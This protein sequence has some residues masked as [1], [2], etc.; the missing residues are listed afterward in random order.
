M[1]LGY[2]EHRN[3]A[4]GPL[5]RRGYEPKTLIFGYLAAH[6]PLRLALESLEFAM[7]PYG[8]GMDFLHAVFCCVIA[9]THTFGL[10]ESHIFLKLG[11]P[12]TECV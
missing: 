3:S 7:A 1:L 8:N 9:A 2:I 6:G 11:L 4:W 12:Q 5:D 10:S